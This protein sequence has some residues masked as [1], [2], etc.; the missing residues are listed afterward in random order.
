M[1]WKVEFGFWFAMGIATTLVAF[2][3]IEP[4]GS[5]EKKMLRAAAPA[6]PVLPSVLVP[7]P[8]HLLQAHRDPSAR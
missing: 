7:I 1:E 3:S 8:D 4:A 2:A 6:G 5:P